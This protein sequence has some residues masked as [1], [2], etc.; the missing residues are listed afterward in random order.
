PGRAAAISLLL[1]SSPVGE[2]HPRLHNEPA[3]GRLAMRRLSIA[4]AAGALS[5]ALVPGAAPAQSEPPALPEGDGKQLVEAVCT[6][7]HQTDQ[8]TRSSGYTQAGWAELTGTM[9][10]LSGSPKD[11]DAIIGYLATNFP[12]N[13]R[14]APERMPGDV[15]IAFEEWQV[16][17]LGQRSRDPVEAPDG[18]IWWAGQWGNLI[19]R[20]DP[21]TGEMTEYPL[22]AN[23]MPHT[24][25]LDDEGNVWYTGNKNATI[26]KLDPATGEITEYPMPDPAA[27]DPHSAKF[28]QDGILWFT[29]QL[30][31]MVGRLDPASGEV[32][33]ATM[34]TPN[35]RPYGIKIDAEGTPWVACNGHNCLVR[36]DPATMEL[37]EIELPTPGTTVRRL[38][39]A[40]D[41]TI[42]YVTYSQ[43]RRGQ[44][45][46]NRGAIGEWPAP[47]GAHL[48]HYS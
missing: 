21:A 1:D 30:S 7:C 9:V 43:R 46:P 48:Q 44:Y 32:K 20:I 11:R 2:N 10:D 13:Q 31:N 33:V 12:P 34:P 17:T 3:S 18:A 6:A 8:I 37:T 47:S 27:K 22:P 41:G 26:G 40:E 5:C 16:P 36:I 4:A 28:D 25:L 14:G 29:M 23:A 24:V 19:G 38:D 42:W 35:S 39:I 15:E 45:D